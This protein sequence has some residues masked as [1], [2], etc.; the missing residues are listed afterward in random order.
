MLQNAIKYWKKRGTVGM[1]KEWDTHTNSGDSPW[2]IQNFFFYWVLTKSFK[3]LRWWIILYILI[4]RYLAYHA[5]VLFIRKLNN[6]P[7]IFLLL[8]YES[9]TLFTLVPWFELS[10]K[11]GQHW[12]KRPVSSHQC[13]YNVDLWHYFIC[14]DRCLFGCCIPRKIRESQAPVIYI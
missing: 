14:A 5:F 8:H 6:N 10:I 11:M 9:L 13:A 1:G 12:I 4:F 2:Y 3:T 7:L